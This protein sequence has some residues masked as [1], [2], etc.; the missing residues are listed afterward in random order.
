MESRDRWQVYG[1]YG[2]TF[3]R[4]ADAKACAKEASQYENDFGEKKAMVWRIDDG[5]NYFTYEDGK[6]T[7]DGWTRPKK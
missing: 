7:R 1:E 2:G 6:L 5:C 3:R 4:L